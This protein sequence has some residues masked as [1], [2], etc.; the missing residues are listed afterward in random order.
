MDYLRALR[1][2]AV[3]FFFV[4]IF[5][6]AKA[7]ATLKTSHRRKHSTTSKEKTVKSSHIKKIPSAVLALL[8]LIVIFA[9]IFTAQAQAQSD[10]PPADQWKFAI[11]PYL[12]LPNVNGTLKYS[13][14]PDT[15]GSPEVETGPNDYLENLQGVLLIAGEVRKD[16]WSV[17][18]DLIYLE[19]ADEQSSVKA[20]D[21]GG[22]IVNSSVNVA[23][24]SSLRGLAWTL[25][26]GY[27]V[28]TGPAVTLD[29]FGGL[30]YFDLTVSTNWQLSADITG[31]GGVQTFPRTGGISKSLT[32]WDGIVGVRGRIPLGSSHWSI[33]YY[34]DIGT[35]S[36]NWTWQG[37]LGID[38]SFKW[39]GVMLAYRNLYYDQKDDK[40]LQDLRFTGPALSV[41]FRF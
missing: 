29:V 6:G 35:G 13:A 37:M 34:L 24:D 5:R 30:R 18:T 23:T 36:S 39:G 32:F 8:M 17:F 4:Q 20:V 15:G 22:S 12:W 14:P 28:E 7:E 3:K 21:F 16:R 2:F 41:T 38:Y 31:P 26:A 11:T 33:P 25:G 1:A 9:T 19:F 40:L 27:A 10:A